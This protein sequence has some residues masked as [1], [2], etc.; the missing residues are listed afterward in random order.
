M[1]ELVCL[2]TSFIIDFLRGKDVARNVLLEL[3]E[4]EEFICVASP[5]IMEFVKGAHLKGNFQKE[6]DNIEKFL[7][8]VF[9]LD[10]DK[11]SAFLA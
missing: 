9:V 5:T 6:I 10:F 1:N 11:K 4:N 8:S 2:E 7:S 3:K